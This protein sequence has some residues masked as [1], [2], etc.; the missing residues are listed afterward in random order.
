MGKGRER[1]RKKKKCVNLSIE[2]NENQHYKWII[3]KP[4]EPKVFSNPFFFLFVEQTTERSTQPNKPLESMQKSH[5]ILFFLFL[6]FVLTHRH[7]L[8]A[9]FSPFLTFHLIQQ[10]STSLP[11][12]TF[13]YCFPN[14][15]IAPVIDVSSSSIVC[16]CVWWRM[17]SI[18]LKESISHLDWCNRYVHQFISSHHLF[19]CFSGR[20][21]AMWICAD[22]SKGIQ[23]VKL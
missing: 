19:Y 16:V 3:D 20:D 12:F 9:I 23:T 22:L 6:F 4:Y 15:A 7:S 14:Y 13:S 8:A 11:L 18:S 5:L 17:A 1:K 2:K 21:K 10:I